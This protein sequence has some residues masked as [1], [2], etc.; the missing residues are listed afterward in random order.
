MTLPKL[1]KRAP[2]CEQEH[3]IQDMADKLHHLSDEAQV[4][5]SFRIE[6]VAEQLVCPIT[7]LQGFYSAHC[8]A[9]KQI[10]S[11][12]FPIL[13]TILLLCSLFHLLLPQR[14]VLYKPGFRATCVSG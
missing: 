8:D 6:K 11:L 2:N 10:E 14:L 7:G 5:L 4:P 1:A 3:M 12:N 9:L 13:G